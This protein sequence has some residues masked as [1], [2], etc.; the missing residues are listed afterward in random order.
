MVCFHQGRYGVEVKIESLFGDN[1]C[2]WVRIVN[3]INKYVTEMSDETHVASV[4][5]KS[6]GKPVAKAEPRQISNLT[7]SP[8]SI[9]CRERQWIDIE[10]GKFDKSCLEVSKLMIRL[11]RHDDSIHREEDGAVRFED[12][13]SVFRSKNEFTSHWS[14][15][16][17]LRFLRKGGGPEKRFWYCLFRRRPL[18]ILHFKTTYCCQT[19]SSSTSI[20][21]GTLTTCTPSISQP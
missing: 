17:W 3:G 21:Y 16:T 20:T 13:A 7:L 8:V 6:T 12:L 5:E 2:S 18:L 19:T 1:T 14:V 4:G 10:P 11:L 9:P 15:Q